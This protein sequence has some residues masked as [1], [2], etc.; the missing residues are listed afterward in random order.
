M[1]VI[2]TSREGE[3]EFGKNSAAGN[4]GSPRC[5]LA[6]DNASNLE[7]GSRKNLPTWRELSTDT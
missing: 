7:L 4:F 5:P 2:S 1:A 6:R 3:L